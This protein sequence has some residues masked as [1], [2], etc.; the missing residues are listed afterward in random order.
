[1]LFCALMWH[2]H[3]DRAVCVQH[4]QHDELYGWKQV[5]QTPPLPLE[6]QVI[7]HHEHGLAGPHGGLEG[8]DGRKQKVIPLVIFSALG[9]T[10]IMGGQGLA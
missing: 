10:S 3:L 1:M 8:D 9:M 5:R 6:L 7:Q 4:S 2:S